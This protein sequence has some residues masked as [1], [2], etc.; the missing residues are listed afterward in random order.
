MG[1]RGGCAIILNKARLISAFLASSTFH[2]RG[3]KPGVVFKREALAFR[4]FES[5]GQPQPS[6]SNLSSNPPPTMMALTSSGGGAD[7]ASS[8][9]SEY[10][11][12]QD[13]FGQKALES[14]K[15]DG[16]E[17]I[18][19]ENDLDPCFADI[20]C[21]SDIIQK[22]E[23][24]RLHQGR[25]GCSDLY[26]RA[27]NATGPLLDADDDTSMSFSVA[28]FNALAEG[29]STG[30][31]D[32]KPFVVDRA[33]PNCELSSL[34]ERYGGF[35]SAPHPSETLSFTKRK[36]RLLEVILGGG[37]HSPATATFDLIGLQ[38][39]DR[40]HG[41]F[42]PALRM[43]GYEGIF[44][45]KRCSPCV[46]AGSYSD[47]C[48][49]FWKAD[50][51]D[52]FAERRVDYRVGNQ[53]CLLASL[54]HRAS[55]N[56]LLVAVTHLKAKN[57]KTNENIRKQ[58]VAQLL[59]SIDEEVARM[60]ATAIDNLHDTVPILILGDFNSDPPSLSTGGTA[61]SSVGLVLEHNICGGPNPAE[62]Q[63]PKFS[64]QSAYEISDPCTDLWTTWK[65][66]G[67]KTTK[68]IIDYIFYAGSV[69]CTSV[70]DVPPSE[71]VEPSKLPG[72]RYPSDH[73]L[74][75]ARFRF[76]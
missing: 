66:R 74:A 53:L 59:I 71:L 4:A 11:P 14:Y 30:P 13:I 52:L 56:V 69:K 68:R 51:F 26:P 28:Q 64:Y 42:A 8:H 18:R 7:A 72:L 32:P 48:C 54:R 37:A 50:K 47:G 58:Q 21:T 17:W 39:V 35:S 12:I 23:A 41:F 63:R 16:T 31:E 2:H 5:R 9:P 70:L 6:F 46:R 73:V 67:K 75:A 40:F 34:D 15:N 10:V 45:P 44:M 1:K 76:V 24:V 60:K 36:W 19:L 27:W 3:K 55:G 65:I 22:I 25:F 57:S 29:L 38:E 62:Q 20:V 33:S 43:F 49:L 61:T